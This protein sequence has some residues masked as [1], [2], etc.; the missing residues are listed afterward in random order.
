MKAL[1]WAYPGEVADFAGA[2]GGERWLAA[3]SRQVEA[4]RDH[5][6][7]CARHLQVCGHLRLVVRT[8]RDEGVDVLGALAQ[9]VQGLGLVGFG[10][11]V[12]EKVLALQG[13]EH[14]DA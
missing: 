14:G 9:G 13:A 3:V 2:V 7:F 10:Q 11:A 1:F 6:D 4:E 8:R 12:Q 5:V